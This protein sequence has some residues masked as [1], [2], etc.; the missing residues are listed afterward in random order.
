MNCVGQRTITR[1]LDVPILALAM[2]VLLG[3]S[4][5]ATQTATTSSRAFEVASVRPNTGAVNVFARV[6]TRAGGS[7]SATNV[8]LRRLIHFA[9]GLKDYDAIEGRSSILDDRFDVIA[10]APEDVPIARPGEVGPLNLMMQSLLAERFKLVV[11]WENRL[12][13]GYA[14]VRLKPEGT[15]GPRIRRSDFDC[16]DPEGREKAIAKN[17][18]GCAF[19]VISNEL[20]ANSRSMPDL[21]QILFLLMQTPVIDHTGIAGS[22]DIE[23]TFDQLEFALPQFKISADPSGAPSLFGAIQDQLGLKLESQQ[24]PAR[25]LVVGNVEPPSAN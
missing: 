22:F 13:P 17:P 1:V 15:L 10:K 21:A 2:L 24:V 23:M 12:R 16:S 9:F 3:W 8:A 19:T 11:R 5:V 6:V 20:K 7:V 18:S 4:S 14:L 25:V